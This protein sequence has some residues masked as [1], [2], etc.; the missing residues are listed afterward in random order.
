MAPTSPLVRRGT[1]ALPEPASA[2]DLGGLGRAQPPEAASTDGGGHA[3]PKAA[4]RPARDAGFLS[5]FDPLAGQGI[6]L[7]DR[8]DVENVWPGWR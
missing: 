3:P 8:E 7:L 5:I 2:G 1:S 4:S 6:L